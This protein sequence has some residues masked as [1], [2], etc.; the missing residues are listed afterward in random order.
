MAA[1]LPWRMRALSYGLASFLI[2]LA[3]T[4]GLYSWA[5]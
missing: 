5:S 2:V 1:A 3:A 4:T